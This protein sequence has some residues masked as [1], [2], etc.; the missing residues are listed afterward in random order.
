MKNEKISIILKNVE[1][2]I[3]SYFENYGFILDRTI[4]DKYSFEFVF[5]YNTLYVKLK[6]SSYPR[7]YPFYI[8]VIVGLGKDFYPESDKNSVALWEIMRYNGDKNAKEYDFNILY[9]EDFTKKLLTD[10]D[11]NI[12]PFLR[13]KKE[14]FINVIIKHREYSSRTKWR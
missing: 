10:I 4:I 5:K 13:E 7:D 3:Y 2:E 9:E 12:L 8:N 11:N 14:E 1:K 6:G